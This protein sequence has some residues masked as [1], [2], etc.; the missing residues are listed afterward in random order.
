MTVPKKPLTTTTTAEQMKV[1]LRTRIAS[2]VVTE[3]QKNE[4]P[5]LRLSP[6]PNAAVTMAMIGRRTITDR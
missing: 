3:S 6:S 2:G 5:S 1:N 4:M